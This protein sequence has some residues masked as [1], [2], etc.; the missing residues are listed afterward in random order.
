MLIAGASL[1]NKQ[2]KQRRNKEDIRKHAPIV[3]RVLYIT[4]QANFHVETLYE[5]LGK[6]LKAKACFA[7]L[8]SSQRTADTYKPETNEIGIGI[9]KLLSNPGVSPVYLHHYFFELGK[10]GDAGPLCTANKA[11]D[12]C[13]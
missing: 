2:L 12:R 3:I 4:F 10:P 6:A 11:S 13:R 5:N 8:Y 7:S 9:G 1:L